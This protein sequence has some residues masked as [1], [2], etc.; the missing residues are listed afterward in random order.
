MLI[1]LTTQLVAFI[2]SQIYPLISLLDFLLKSVLLVL[3]VLYFERVTSP[4]FTNKQ[5]SKLWLVVI[6]LLGLLPFT[7]FAANYLTDLLHTTRDFTLLTVLIP[8]DVEAQSI[9]SSTIYL[10][11]KNAALSIYIAVL[12]LQLCKL[13]QSLVRIRNIRNSAKFVIPIEAQQLLRKLCV[14]LEIPT[15]IQLGISSLVQTPITFGAARPVIILPDPIYCR[16]LEL[17]ENVLLHELSHVKRRDQ[18]NFVFCYFIASINWFNPVIWFA[19]KR[20]SV[21][22]EYACDDEVICHG[23]TPNLFASQLIAIARSMLLKTENPVTGKAI[24]ARGELT[25]RLENILHAN[26]RTLKGRSH[27]SSLPINTLLLV[28]ILA[29]TGKLLA[30][31]NEDNYVTEDLRLVYSQ[32]PDFPSAALE[33]GAIGYTQFV[34]SV[35]ESGKIEPDSIIL[36][37]SEPRHLFDASSITALNNFKFSPRRVNGRTLATAGVRYRFDFNIKISI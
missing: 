10:N 37:V 16:D 36:E 32:L 22:A 26:C 6:I 18:Q 27:S 28:F 35:D 31:E 7:L 25:Q 12:I 30:L 1:E 11:W 34:F 20:Y 9:D 14:Q 23:K 5:K 2:E 33:K 15:K 3:L 17:L 4:F 19:L 13:T 21:E 29:S 24:L 8:Y